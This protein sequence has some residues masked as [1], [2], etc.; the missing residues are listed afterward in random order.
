MI[1]ETARDRALNRYGIPVCLHVPIAAVDEAAIATYVG[2]IRAV[3]SRRGLRKAFLVEAYPPEPREVAY[4]IWEDPRSAILHEPLQVWVYVGFTRYRQAWR[5][6]FPDVALGEAVLSH[7][8]NRRIAALKGFDFVRITPTSRNANSSSALSEGWGVALHSEH[9]QMAANRGRGVFI[10]YADITGLMLML[11]MRLGGGV[12]DA[13]NE[14]R[15]L[16]RPLS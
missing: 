16:V 15:R 9:H 5:R 1:D 13:V 12:M 6:A 7:A 11:D 3:L 8:L 14:G 2:E 4:P 10:E